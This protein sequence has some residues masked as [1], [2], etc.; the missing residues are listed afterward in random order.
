MIEWLK[1][2]G[3]DPEIELGGSSVP[4]EL[5]RMKRAKR[6]TLRLAADGASVTI[7]MPTWCSTREAVEF[8]HSRQDWLE[9]QL[10]KVVPKESPIERGSVRYKGE[11]LGL[12]WNADAP[13]KPELIE[14]VSDE[15]PR[16][17]KLRLGGPR[18]TLE[19][20]LARWLA[21]EALEA[22]DG[23]LAFYCE[24]AGKT[25]PDLK[26]SRAKRRWGSC[27]SQG[28]V[29]LNWRLIQAPDFVRQS[30]VAHETAHL[31][32]F[33]HSPAFHAL[34]AKIYGEDIGPADRWLKQNGRTL[35]ADFG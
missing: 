17:R 20:R 19:R 23:D 14:V 24:R 10:A 35:Y 25:K 26:L 13:R 11:M 18:E 5:K 4:I 33:D 8:A 9:A 30:V 1:S 34:L 22:M 29:R 6:L 15:E 12:E 31:T 7:T 3:R 32:H 16:V 2:A 21:S 28:T 27:S